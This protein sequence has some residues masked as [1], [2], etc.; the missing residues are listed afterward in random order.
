MTDREQY[1]PGPAS[2]AQ[3][4]KDGEKWT[5]ILAREL[6]QPGI[7]LLKRF[8]FQPVE[9][10]LC[11]YRGF[12]ETGIAQH[13][14]VLGHSRLRH[15]KLTLNLSHRLLGGDQQAQD[16]AAVRL[17]ND[18]EHRF[19]FVIY[20]PHGIYVSRHIWARSSND[21]PNRSLFL[22]NISSAVNLL[23]WNAFSCGT[24]RSDTRWREGR[25]S[26]LKKQAVCR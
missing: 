14:Q 10:A 24:V 5:L 6:S 13:A 22:R 1:T 7:H 16:R 3:V 21:A 8:R 15:T 4:R 18:F 12:H 11:V 9:T 2:G 19:H 20:T 25:K 26:E 17:R 23:M